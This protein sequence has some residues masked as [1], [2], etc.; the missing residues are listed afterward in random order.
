M[1]LVE[2]ERNFFAGIDIGQ[3]QDNT[4]VAIVERIRA[5]ARADLHHALVE[6]AREEAAAQPA[7]LQLRHLERLQLGTPYPEQVEI[8]RELLHR[9]Q[10]R[11]VQTYLDA[12]GVGLGPY[13]MLRKVGV[14]DLHAIKITGSVG[15]AKEVPGGWNVGKAELVNAVQIEMQTGRLGT[16]MKIPHVGQLVHELRNFRARQSPSGSLSFNAR[17]GQHDDLV[18]AVA[19][20]VFGALRPSPVTHLDV[21]FAA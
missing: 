4:T 18:L 11:G 6:Q 7:K 10:I 17:E 12:T 1:S 16:S 20:A 2:F 9:P 21:R 14:R 5:R 8:L 13:Q 19:Y 3:V 15:A